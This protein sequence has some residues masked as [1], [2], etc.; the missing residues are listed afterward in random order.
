MRPSTCA[1]A[2]LEIRLPRVDRFAL[3]HLAATPVA[4][5]IAAAEPEARQKIGS[6]VTA[7]SLQR[8]ADGDGIAYPEE[9]YV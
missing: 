6:S 2:E 9:T 4:A 7:S 3:D 5:V 1:S 8:F